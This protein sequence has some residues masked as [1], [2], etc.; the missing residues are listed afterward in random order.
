MIR[1]HQPKALIVCALGVGLLAASAAQAAVITTLTAVPNPTVVFNPVDFVADITIS[2]VTAA[3]KFTIV[4][5]TNYMFDFGDG[6]NT[7]LL[8]DMGPFPNGAGV[9][10]A[11]AFEGARHGYPAAGVYNARFTGTLNY[12]VAGPA[13]VVDPTVQV[14][15][16]TAVTVNAVPEPGTSV[17][18][19]SG[20][21]AILLAFSGVNRHGRK[22]LSR[23]SLHTC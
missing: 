4:S 21:V 6:T 5:V 2:D 3:R 16:Q 10:P 19:A 12:T 11:S 23:R 18:I 13:G 14:E 22:R 1:I 17:M 7:G 9:N 15:A 8:N 20:L